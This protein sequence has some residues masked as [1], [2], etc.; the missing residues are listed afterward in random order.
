VT[1]SSVATTVVY[2]PMT[3]GGM[4]PIS[5]PLSKLGNNINPSML[6]SGTIQASSSQGVH[7]ATPAPFRGPPGGGPP[8]GSGVGPPGAGP[9]YSGGP[10]GGAGSAWQ[11]PSNPNGPPMYPNYTGGNPFGGSGGGGPGGL[12]GPG[13]PG[14]PGGGGGGGPPFGWIPPASTGQGPGMSFGLSGVPVQTPATAPV[15]HS[16]QKLTPKVEIVKLKLGNVDKTS[17]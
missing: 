4:I 10:P 6:Q 2:V 15:F 13:G 14:G 8:Y 12:G 3:N 5:L 9:P 1:H 16:Q 11:P 7:M 17:I